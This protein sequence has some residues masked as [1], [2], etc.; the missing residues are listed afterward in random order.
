MKLLYNNNVYDFG[1]ESNLAAALRNVVME[2]LDE[3]A[4]IVLKQ[5]YIGYKGWSVY[6]FID[7]LLTTYGEKT[8]DMVNASLDAIT[9]EFDCSG[10]LI[11]QLYLRQDELQEF[12]VGTAGTVTYA[13]WMLHTTHVIESS[14]ILNKAVW[15]WQATTTVYKTKAQFILD[16]NEYHKDYHPKFKY[17][18][19]PIAHNVQKINDVIG[20]LRTMML[21][22]NNVINQIGGRIVSVHDDASI[23]STRSNI[24]AQSQPIQSPPSSKR[25]KP[26]E[27]P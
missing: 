27:L 12:A 4:Y 10:A 20:E 24:P 11:E 22:Q 19:T 26:S 2:K 21:E 6:E 23:I 16:F 9:A 7:H 18:T 1:L 5:Q 25:F 17:T 8:D 3:S 14:G 15:K 13:A